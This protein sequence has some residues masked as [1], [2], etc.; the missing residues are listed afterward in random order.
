MDIFDLRNNIIQDYSSFLKSYLKI[1]DDR[2]RYFVESE[3]NK[4][5]LWPDSIL[6]LNPSYEYG[7]TIQELCNKKILN[8]KCS[9]FF[10]PKL[11][12][13]RHQE[14]AINLALMKEN[15]ILTTGTGSGKSMTYLIP[16]IDYIFK[17]R[18]DE[19][20]VRAIIVYPMNALINSQYQSLESF[21]SNK[22]LDIFY[23]KYTG[24]EK[25]EL[26]REIREKPPHIILTNYVMLEYMLLRP[27][28]SIFVDK[29][30][31][32]IKFLVLDELHTYR[33]R[34]GSDIAYLIRRLKERSGNDNIICIGTSAT[35]S[36]ENSREKKKETVAKIA[37][38]LFGSTFKNEN[39]IDETISRK[40]VSSKVTIEDL[41]SGIKKHINNDI[42]YNDFIS[43]PI[44]IWL[45]E[46]FGIEEINGFYFRK[47]P[48]TLKDGILKL[49]EIT[50]YEIDKCEYV[51]KQYLDL[52][53]K[54]KSPDNNSTFPLKIH[55]FIS[56]G[57]AVYSTIQTQTKGI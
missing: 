38:K 21:S 26:R 2:I 37:S 6:Q 4:G 35:M 32:D 17:N 11:K 10:G 49:S 34:Q 23:A 50:G 16:I 15:Y 29:L 56:Q 55:Q 42:S 44:A 14:E 24:Q 12:L 3:L 1:S 52:G 43:N 28:E 13:Y 18:P 40:T 30:L 31:S 45:E 46:Y 9:D 22:N 8:E 47:K 53:S 7:S 25:D 27:K 51:I 54:I 20:K 36:A 19:R 39:V 48:R 5:V 57:G 33:G 41:K